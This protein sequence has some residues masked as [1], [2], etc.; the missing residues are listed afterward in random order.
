MQGKI[1]FKGRMCRNRSCE[2]LSGSDELARERFGP[3]KIKSRKAG[4]LNYSQRSRAWRLH[5]SV[6]NLLSG[7]RE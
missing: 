4:A 2:S 6:L 5:V 3:L 7:A 1:T